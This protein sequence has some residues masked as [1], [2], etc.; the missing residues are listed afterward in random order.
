MIRISALI[1][2][3]RG[4]RRRR[5]FKSDMSRQIEKAL[6]YWVAALVPLYTLYYRNNLP[7]GDIR[8]IYRYEYPCVGHTESTNRSITITVTT[9]VPSW[10]W[11]QVYSSNAIH[12]D[13]D[14]AVILA[15]PSSDLAAVISVTINVFSCCDVFIVVT[16][17]LR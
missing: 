11:V 6:I 15:L 7:Y 5:F 1:E 2:E 12:V 17:L 8:R 16:L 9:R 3:R 13:A 14:C 4:C 10:S